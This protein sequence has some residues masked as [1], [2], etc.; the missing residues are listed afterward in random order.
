MDG[1]GEIITL[2][3]NGSYKTNDDDHQTH[4]QGETEYLCSIILKVE[5]MM[6]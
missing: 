5:G 3:P 4:L 6:P 1:K 2:T